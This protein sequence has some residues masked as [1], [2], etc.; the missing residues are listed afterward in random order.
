M[1]RKYDVLLTQ[2]GDDTLSTLFVVMNTMQQISPVPIANINDASAWIENVPFLLRRGIPIEEARTL[3]WRFESS[4]ATVAIVPSELIFPEDTPDI[5]RWRNEWFSEHLVAL[6]ETVLEYW[7]QDAEAD[8]AYRFSYLPT[9]GRDVTI[10]IWREGEHHFGSVRRSIGSIGPIPGPPGYDVQWV[11][12]ADDWNNLSN[13]IQANAFWNS[14]SWDTVPDGFVVMDSAHWVVEGWR[15]KQYHVL[16]DQTPD[17]GAAREV[18]LL[19][20]SLLPDEF[21]ELEAR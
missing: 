5:T 9:L 21:T 8:E 17:E 20:L 11:A 6:R 7:A 19:L 2:A 1:Y 4:D 12:S 13:I 18:G 14:D 15:D 3:Q 10:R 16:F